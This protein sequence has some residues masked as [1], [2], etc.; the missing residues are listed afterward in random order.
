MQPKKG[1]ITLATI[2]NLKQSLVPSALDLPTF[3]RSRAHPEIKKRN[4]NLVL[5]QANTTHS[6]RMA[7]AYAQSLRCSQSLWISADLSNSP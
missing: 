2:S 4:S 6:A 3:R 1:K 7:Q 5:V